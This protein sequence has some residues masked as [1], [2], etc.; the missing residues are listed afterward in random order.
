MAGEALA[1]GYDTS[2]CHPRPNV[3][4]TPLAKEGCENISAYFEQTYITPA[5]VVSWVRTLNTIIFHKPK[6]SYPKPAFSN[7]VEVFPEKASETDQL[8]INA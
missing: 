4:P 7:K 8:S 2:L 1:G 3:V 6:T 5:R